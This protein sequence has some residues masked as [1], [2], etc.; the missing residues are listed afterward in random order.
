MNVWLANGTTYRCTVVAR[1]TAAAQSIEVLPIAGT[2]GSGVPGNFTLTNQYQQ[3]T[4]N[5]FGQDI[6]TLCGVALR[7]PAGA[8]GNI[9]IQSISFEKL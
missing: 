2:A 8:T 4:L 7:R 6:N 1:S 5:V 9:H 3:Y